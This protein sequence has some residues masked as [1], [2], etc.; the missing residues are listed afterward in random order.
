V[1]VRPHLLG[2][3]ALYSPVKMFFCEDAFSLFIDLSIVFLQLLLPEGAWNQREAPNAK[4]AL[5]RGPRLS[6]AQPLR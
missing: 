2:Q 3:R 6:P 4:L 1:N 5:H